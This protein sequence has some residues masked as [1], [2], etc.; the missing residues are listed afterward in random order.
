MATTTGAEPGWSQNPIA[1]FKSLTCVQ[2][3]KRLRYALPAFPG[4]L[5]GS[6]SEMEQHYRQPF[7]HFVT[8]SAPKIRI[9]EVQSMSTALF[10]LFERQSETYQIPI[11]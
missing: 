3:P 10:C 11:C 9:I 1:S 2:V 8:V 5:Q 4:A 7:I 6:E